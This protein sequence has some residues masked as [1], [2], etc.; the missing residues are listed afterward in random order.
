VN[1]I[2]NKVSSFTVKIAVTDGTAGAPTCAKNAGTTGETNNLA[3]G[4]C[5]A[6][7]GAKPAIEFVE[8]N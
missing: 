8:A 1:A 5:I 4:S 6:S 7:G 3:L 2:F